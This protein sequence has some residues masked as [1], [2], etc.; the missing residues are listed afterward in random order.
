MKFETIAVHGGYSPDPTTK[1][2]AV[3]IYQTTSYAFDDTQHG[4]DQIGRQQIG[5]ELHPMEVALHA[6]RQGLDGGGLGQTGH[7][8]DKKVSAGQQADQHGI[9]QRLLAD[10]ARSDMGPERGQSGRVHGFG[11]FMIICCRAAHIRG[12]GNG[13]QSR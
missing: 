12:Q 11:P 1:A 5:G 7:A 13:R 10:H 4:A 2:V 3:P 9:D 8:F 6:I